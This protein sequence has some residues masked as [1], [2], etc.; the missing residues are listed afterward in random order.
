VEVVTG[1]ASAIYGSDAVA[2]VVNFITKKD[3]EGIEFEV[4]SGFNTHNNDN[5]FAQSLT[6]DAGFDVPTGNHTDGH[7]QSYSLI[8]GANSSDGRG[9]FT[10]FLTYQN[11]D[12]VRS[13]ARDFGAG[14]LFLDTDATN[15]PTGDVFMSGSGNSN[16]FEPKSG[17]NA[18]NAL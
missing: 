11:Q 18:N 4:Q 3:Y 13:D 8:G 12:G 6:R 10:V 15:K 17:P 2:G 9:N 1:G 14:Q 5:A 16:W 7:V